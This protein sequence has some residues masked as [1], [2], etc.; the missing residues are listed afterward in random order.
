MKNKFLIVLFLVVPVFVFSQERF[1]IRA[2]TDTAGTRYMDVTGTESDTTKWF[3]LQHVSSIQVKTDSLTAPPINFSIVL[4]VSNFNDSLESF[5]PVQ[6][7]ATF[8]THCW[9]IIKP[10]YTPT[11][12][13]GKFV[14]TGISTNDSTRVW[15]YH[16]G[17]SAQ[18]STAR[19]MH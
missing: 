16:N 4:L 18:E 7:L 15:V 17:W 14:Y 3:Y 12:K 1:Y 8:T 5:K 10:I 13:F 2:V 19:N 11:A 6:T 9:Q